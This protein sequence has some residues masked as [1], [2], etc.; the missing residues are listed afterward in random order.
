MTY[1]RKR[2]FFLAQVVLGSIGSSATTAVQGSLAESS[3]M[4]PTTLSLRA[5]AAAVFDNGPFFDAFRRVNIAN[6]LGLTLSLVTG[7]HYHLDLVGTGAFCFAAFPDILNENLTW[8]SR[9]S[10]SA[11]CLWSVKLASFLFRRVLKVH[12]DSRLTTTLES[13]GGT[14]MFWTISYVWNLL[15]LLPHSIGATSNIKGNVYAQWFGLGMFVVG[16]AFETVADF[17]KFQFKQSGNSKSFCNVGLFRI[18]QHPNYFGNL[19]LWSGIF[20]MNAPALIEPSEKT[21]REVGIGK[22]VLGLLWR[23]RRLFL[24][25]LS[26][27][28]LFTLFYGQANGTISNSLETAQKKHGDNPDYIR[29]VNEVP[30]IF[31]KFR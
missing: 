4:I 28:F 30:L 25:L 16:L 20:V 17:Q 3:K 13:V 8:R 27:L 29:Y 5:G 15:T 26:P 24:S 6:I 23:T 12:H 10:A 11:V 18:S 31:P 7:S 19:L 22:F 2:N 14:I 21:L 1:S 9:F